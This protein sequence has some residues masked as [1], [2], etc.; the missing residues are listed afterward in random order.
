MD[1]FFLRRSVIYATVDTPLEGELDVA[2]LEYAHHYPSY[3]GDYDSWEDEQNAQAQQIL[4]NGKVDILMGTSIP[5]S[6]PKPSMPTRRKPT[7]SLS[8][9]AISHRTW[10]L[11]RLY[12]GVDN[13]IASVED[14]DLV[15]DHIF[16]D[17][18]Y[19]GRTLT[20][21]QLYTETITITDRARSVTWLSDH[22]GIQ[23]RWRQRKGLTNKGPKV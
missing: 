13:P 2:S 1:Y 11:L 10:N 19:R 20:S 9:E 12:L 18:S 6:K 5:V 23:F 15:L 22:A 16:L 4:A 7:R 8:M 3:L 17:E 21:E 14:G